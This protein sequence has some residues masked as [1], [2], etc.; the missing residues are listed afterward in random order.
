MIRFSEMVLPGH[1]DKFCDQVADAIVARAA[2]LDAEAYCQVEVG[3]WCDQLWVSGGFTLPSGASLPLGPV[4]DEVA[5]RVGYRGADGVPKAFTVADTVCRLRQDPRGWTRKV[6]DQSIC[7]G[8]AGYDAAT[9]YLPPE[10]FLAHALREALVAA[11]RGGELRGQGPDGKLLVVMAEEGKLWRL[12]RVLATVEQ[13]GAPYGASDFMDFSSRVA[14]TLRGAYEAVRAHD[15][16]WAADWETVR[17]LVN[18]NGPLVAAGTECDNGQTGRKLA[19]DYYGPRVGQGG[20]ALSGK[21]LSHIDRIGAYAAR[22]AAVAAVRSGAVSCRVTAAWA[23]N[24]PDPLEVA[25]ETEGRG[26]VWPRSA[27]GHD[28]MLERFG[29][30]AIEPAWAEGTHFWDG[31]ARWNGA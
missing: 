9:R 25:Y 16:R 30:A 1:P 19:M 12:E 18:P 7:V 15:R 2:A 5:E 17:C 8:W 20:G 4:V 27:F 21:H 24:I 10:H 29:N 23:P 11:I 22:A 14:A 13:A 6:N 31:G 28:A 3:A 26:E